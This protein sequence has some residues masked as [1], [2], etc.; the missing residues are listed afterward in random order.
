[1]KLTTE[2]YDKFQVGKKF[3]GKYCAFKNQVYQGSDSSYYNSNGSKNSLFD[4]NK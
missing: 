2:K 3:L 1:M 4:N